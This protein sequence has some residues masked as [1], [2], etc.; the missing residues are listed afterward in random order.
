MVWIVLVLHSFL[1]LLSLIS[2]V[3]MD[4]Q[5]FSSFF[6]VVGLSTLGEE[7]FVQNIQ[8]NVILYGQLTMEKFSGSIM[9]FSKKHSREI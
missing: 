7:K 1:F 4:F 3:G 8:K 6:Q 5:I 9:K 2:F